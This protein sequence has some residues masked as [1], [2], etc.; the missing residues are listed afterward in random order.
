MSAGENSARP[1]QVLAA[2]PYGG[3][4]A[5][6]IVDFDRHRPQHVAAHLNLQPGRF[7]QPAQESGL[8]RVGSA[9]QLYELTQFDSPCV[10]G[11][12][13]SSRSPSGIICGCL[14]PADRKST[15]LNSSHVAISYAVFCLKKKRNSKP[16]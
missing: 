9:C 10:G 8:N 3:S 16:E 6:G 7:E 4:G 12:V 1:E 14:Q 2:H 5:V 11:P 13:S 15:R